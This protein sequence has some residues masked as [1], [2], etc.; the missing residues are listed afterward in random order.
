MGFP[1][2]FRLQCAVDALRG[3]EIVTCPTEGVWGLSC[4]PFDAD[5]VFDLLEL[6]Q[7]P[8]DKG[9]ILVAADIAQLDLFLK[10][11]GAMQRKTLAAS[12]P[13][14]NTWLVPCSRDVPWWIS[15]GQPTVAL[16]VSAHP[17][18]RAL[19]AG[20]GSAIVSTS[21][22]L[23]GK[24]AAR[25]LLDVQL[26]F[27]SHTRLRPRVTIVPGALGCEGRPSTIRD[28]QTGKIIRH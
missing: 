12:W 27:A 28:L 7:R 15:G 6:K 8:L 20:F 23:S 11:L 17:V 21:A 3:G 2:A 19:C 4:D 14:P 22:N 1:S 16:R 25:S 9:L 24:P 10:G 26:Q 18:V 13:G 5:A